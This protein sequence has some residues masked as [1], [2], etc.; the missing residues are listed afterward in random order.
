MIQERLVILEHNSGHF[1]QSGLIVSAVQTFADRAELVI[2]RPGVPNT[3]ATLRVGGAVLLETPDGIFEARVMSTGN[4]RVEVLVT[5]V[6]PRPGI[7]AGF[8]DQSVD[9]LPF[10]DEELTKISDSFDTIRNAM[11]ARGD[12]TEAQFRLL[13]EKLDEMKEASTRFGRKDWIHYVAGSLTATAIAAAFAPAVTKDLLR[14]AGAALSW[15]L[16]HTLRLLT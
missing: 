16:G 13:S 9:N 4:T 14:T 15:A 12:L 7:A 1:D 3:E 5:Q 8:V 11:Q 2:G 10:S 6:S